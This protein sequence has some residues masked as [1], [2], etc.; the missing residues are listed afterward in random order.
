MGGPPSQLPRYPPSMTLTRIPHPPRSEAISKEEFQQIRYSAWI[1]LL[2]PFRQRFYSSWRLS[3]NPQHHHPGKSPRSAD[4]ECL[5]TTRLQSLDD[6]IK[7][8]LDC[9]RQMCFARGW[10]A[11][12]GCEGFGVSQTCKDVVQRVKLFFSFILPENELHLPRNEDTTK[13]S[14]ILSLAKTWIN[15]NFKFANL[16]F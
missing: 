16:I 9:G 4:L 6:L 13:T 14:R 15:E 8:N 1:L 3:F 11:E 7:S 5:D 2:N 12:N 10:R